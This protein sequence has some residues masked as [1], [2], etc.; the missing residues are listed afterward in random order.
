MITSRLSRTQLR[1]KQ[2][3]EPLFHSSTGWLKESTWHLMGGWWGQSE[4]KEAWTSWKISGTF[5]LAVKALRHAGAGNLRRGSQHP[6]TGS[7][8]MILIRLAVSEFQPHWRQFAIRNSTEQVQH[9]ETGIPTYADLCRR[10]QGAQSYCVLRINPLDLGSVEPGVTSYRP[11]STI[12]QAYL[13]PWLPCPS[14]LQST[15]LLEPKSGSVL[16]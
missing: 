14:I 1:S 11:T 9:T 8:C 7:A 3:T 5:P 4:P 2:S 16:L 15:G 13:P 10:A 6:T 12:R